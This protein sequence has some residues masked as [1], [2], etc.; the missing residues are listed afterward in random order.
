MAVFNYLIAI[1]ISIVAGDDYAASRRTACNH[2]FAGSFVTDERY[3]AD[4]CFSL[5][6]DALL[7]LGRTVPVAE[8]EAAA[9]DTLLKFIIRVADICFLLN[10]FEGFLIDVGLNVFEQGVDLVCDAGER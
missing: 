4:C 10:V 7:G 9:L 8:E 6:L 5:L 1:G 2:T 3:A